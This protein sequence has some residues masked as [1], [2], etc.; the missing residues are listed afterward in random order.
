MAARTPPRTG[1]FA[2]GRRGRS[3]ARADGA[4]KTSSA[5]FPQWIAL[6]GYILLAV[7]MTWPL[8]LHLGTRLGGIDTDILNVY[9]GNWWVREALASGQNPYVT[10]YLIY[11]IGFDLTTF[12]F[13]PVLAL[14]WIP[15]SWVLS[16]IAAYNLVVW[17]TI[18][19]C[20]VA[21][22]QLVR[23]LT[24]NAWA[25]WAAGLTFGFSSCLVAERAAHL[26]MAMVAWIPW[27]ALLVTRLMREARVRDAILLAVAIVLSFLTRLQVGALVLIFAGIYW[28]GLALVER[29]EWH[30]MAGRRLLLAGTLS[31]LF[32]APLLV[33][34]WQVLQ[35]PGGESLLRWQAE[36]SQ[37]DLLAYVLPP[38]RHP[39]FGSWTEAVYEQRFKENTFYWAYVGFTPLLLLA[40]A[41]V[42]RVRK[43]W[44]WLLA[45]LF[46][47]ILA[48]GPCLRL[49][50]ELYPAL[51]L[52]YGLGTG[53]FS[54]IGFDVPNRF[55]LAL[56]PAVS[57]LVGLASAQ[58]AA[59][60]GRPWLPSLFAA[61]ILFEYLAVPM[62]LKT[63]PPHSPFYDQMAADGED[64]AIVD[65]PLTRE[66]GEFHRY[67]Q[68][69]HHKPI[70]GGWDHRVP[71]SAFAFVDENPLL[72]SWR[73]IETPGVPLDAA[74]DA[75]AA[76]NV[77]YI[78]VHKDELE[79]VPE[80]VRPLFFTL[81]PVYEDRSIYVLPVQARS[82]QQY[83]LV[84]Q[85][86]AGV[87]WTQ[88]TISASTGEPASANTPLLSLSTCWL[89]GEASGA[90]D[91]LQVT[92]A[93]P[94]GL[95]A[96]ESS[97][98]LA[99]LTQGLACRDWPLAWEPSFR[100]GEYQ[101]QIVDLFAGQPAF[102]WTLTQS[103]QVVQDRTGAS[104]PLLGRAFHVPY[105]AP[106]EMLAYDVTAGD[107]LLWV[108]LYWRS[109]AEQYQPYILSL[110]L[111]DQ[112]SGQRVAA[113]D[114]VLPRLQWAAGE[115][116]QE[117]RIVMIN[118]VPPGQYT[119]GAALY[120][121]GQPGNRIA[122]L[123]ERS[124]KP[125]PGNVAV[126]DLP[127]L[128]LS[129]ASRGTP[130]S[131][132]G[133]VV[134]YAAA[135]PEA[136]ASAQHPLR[137]TLGDVARL[138]GYS[139]EPEEAVAQEKLVFTLFWEAINTEPLDVDYKVFVHLLDESGQVI[140]QHDGEP[141][142]G[143][144]PTHTWHKGDPI[145]DSH[146]IVWL[147]QAYQG[148]ATVEV[149]LYHP[150]TQERV[151]A[152]G[153]QGERLPDDRVILGTIPVRTP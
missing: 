62:P 110:Q 1:V 126:L 4:L 102:T 72:G 17:A 86:S 142:A 109:L 84:Q 129:A 145:A 29:K 5:W 35:Q 70:V 19:L 69:I 117:R 93:G 64:Y 63:P 103:V 75:L 6:L 144:Q 47:F 152:Y 81:R 118:D 25:A 133:R 94:G 73:G 78:V 97:A 36:N 125:W 120:Y 96:Y 59:R 141:A 50:G 32:L 105:D 135:S 48:L 80:A 41:G 127:V 121:P 21:M 52:P 57:V 67:F 116:V 92:W 100:P 143:R 147:A 83:N 87:A 90:G 76:A 51:K 115:I 24:G 88:P 124:G 134:V 2:I 98:P 130:V 111:L 11:P 61:L 53:L 15:A 99:P 66:A 108:D 43:A 106:I 20:C 68:T 79:G 74:L 44:P 45:G 123:D 95:P 139:V 12:A 137:A 14:L 150:Q 148:T 107:G 9:W 46:F 140:A 28:L 91:T 34:A 56:M 55:N 138:T 113:S 8:A 16:P 114:G 146:E 18:V 49:N 85:S 112:Q 77:R 149:G 60:L 58:I 30:G 39:L 89:P 22:D 65:L 153:P 31:C 38:P 42:S 37:T 132:E 27:T 122:A 151:P 33:H 82:S 10:P 40:Y 7:L 131:E 128:V 71:D 136:P 3:T 104:L 119:L 26:N 23:Y 13:S 101:A 54:A